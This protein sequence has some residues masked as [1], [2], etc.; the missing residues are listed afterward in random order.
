[1]KQLFLS[2]LCLF[3]CGCTSYTSQK[4]STQNDHASNR[5]LPNGHFLTPAGT[6][7][8]TGEFPL[9]M[10]LSPDKKSLVV[11][12][13]GY[14][15]QT[16]SIVNV[17]NRSIMQ[18]LPIR[19]SWMGAAWGPYGDYFFVTAGNDNKVYR[20]GFHNDSAWY[21]NSIKL[22]EEAPA[23]FISPTGLAITSEG[24]KIYTVSRITPALY[25]LDAYSN[26]I[27]KT[28]E[29]SSP[30]YSCVLDEVRKLIYVSEW[31]SAKVAVVHA[32]DLVSIKEIEVGNHPSA[33]VM[34]KKGTHLFVS[35]SGE[36]NVSVINLQ[37]LLVEEI[38]DVALK[39][40]SPIGS[41]PNALAM[42]QGD[43]TLYVALA[44][45]NAVAVVK[46]V[47]IGK[48]VVKGFIP[49][50]WYPTAIECADS[51][52]IVANGRG[53]TSGKNLNKENVF[54]YLKGTLS[55]IPVPSDK[56]LEE[57][58][59]AVLSNNPYTRE[60]SFS[61][62]NAD[63]P[64]PHSVA[65]SKKSPIK[66]LFYVIKEMRSYDDLFGDMIIGNGDTLFAK[67]GKNVVPNHQ[68][69]AEEFVL[70]DNFYANGQNSVNGM[71]W[72][73]GAY[74]TD[75]T[76]K[77]VPTLFGRRGGVYNYEHD[78]I[79]SP[80]SG[81]LWDAAKKI[82]LTVR[83]YGMFIDE[84][85]STRGEI[86]PLA[87]RLFNI[88]S[89]IYRGW[90]LNYSDTSR[91]A[92]WMKEFDNYERGDSLPRL[93]LIRLPNDHTNGRVSRIKS[94]NAFVA[95]NDLALGK[96]V[97]RISHSKYW[98][99]SAI[100]VLESSANGGSD[101]VDAHRSAMFIISP[102]SK[103]KFVDSRHYTTTSVLKTIELI[104]GIPPMTQH[105]AGA[106]P[107]YRS[108]QSVPDTTAYSVKKNIVP[109]NELTTVSP[110]NLQK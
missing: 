16:L 21:L 88:T 56:E 95:D 108:F 81:Y 93:S 11:V 102:Y 42:G 76:E 41:T 106:V 73:V 109:L 28:L 14:Y 18:T 110:Q 39:V 40:G 15:Q 89:P 35:N 103:R 64:I 25:K 59:S 77:T 9:G 30:L 46:I 10:A 91:I 48:S 19:K 83:N 80:K 1:M 29:F 12:N 34:N 50:G 23:A 99:E 2:V 33:M 26:T 71:Q 51:V 82:N 55:F 72:S 104:L 75:Y 87:K 58:T 96:L 57:Y 4:Q 105:D 5:W 65:D 100:F 60:Q 52:L 94:Q 90:D 38:I 74:S 78:G 67:Y 97:E 8:S 62:W 70:F 44:D 31:G 98:K 53:E 84:E 69:L 36:N 47:T 86:I 17:T 61:D 107:L 24:D 32:D 20:Y 37:T 68:S 43:S 79:A 6:S 54:E 66:Y 22:A 49:V 3:L 27:E 85:A 7:I 45:N 63:N 92:A 101:H 13:S